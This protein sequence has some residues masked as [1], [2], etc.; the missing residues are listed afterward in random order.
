MITVSRGSLGGGRVRRSY[1][2]RPTGAR[3][4]NSRWL[5]KEIAARWL[6]GSARLN[7][8]A[9]I[10]PHLLPTIFSNTTPPNQPSIVR[11][12]FYTATQ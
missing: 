3:K 10:A 4:K 6:V 1:F 7:K 2:F 12:Y 11:K 9:K 8:F 5:R